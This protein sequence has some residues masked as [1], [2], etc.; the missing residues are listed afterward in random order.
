MGRKKKSKVSGD[1]LRAKKS[2][3]KGKNRRKWDE[4]GTTAPSTPMRQRISAEAESKDIS[5]LE[6]E[7]GIVV[8]VQGPYWEVDLASDQRLN[9]RVAR[10]VQSENAGETLVCAGDNVLVTRIDELDDAQDAGEGLI[11]KVLERET[12]LMRKAPAHKG[13]AHIIAANMDVLVVFVAA[14]DPFYNKRLIDRYLIAAQQ[15]ELAACIFVNK[16]DL[17][18]VEVMQEDLYVYEELGVPVFF[19]S[20]TDGAGVQEA[21]EALA[22]KTCVISGPSGAGKSTF[23]NA[24]FGLEVQD[25][26]E[27][28]TKTFKGMHTTTGARL[29]R[30]PGGGYLVDTPGIREFGV[31]DLEPE[32][33]QWYFPEIEAVQ[34]ECKFHSCTHV[35]EPACAVQA[36]V[37]EG[38]VHPDRYQSYLNIVQTL[39]EA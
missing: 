8:G 33:V 38:R 7:P 14:A 39:Q 31:W 29:L 9:C 36:A 11:Y 5:A 15:G 25:T 13:G 22:D 12:K 30:T 17:F 6:L 19:L 32:Q 20:S 3:R 35:H 24:V 26:G 2:W 27:I 37:E 23:I 16:C 10:S 28:S 34:Q 21:Y 1:A 18:D 4:E